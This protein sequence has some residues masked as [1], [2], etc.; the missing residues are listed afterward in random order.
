MPSRQATISFCIFM[1][2]ITTSGSPTVTASPGATAIVDTIP[3]IG[4]VSHIG[5]LGTERG[6]LGRIDRLRSGRPGPKA[7]MKTLS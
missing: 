4:A 1:L 5:L 7:W 6:A 2:S 3:G